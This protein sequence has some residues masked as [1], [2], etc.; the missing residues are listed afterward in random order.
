MPILVTKLY[1]PPSRPNIVL[2]PRLVDVLNGG[3]N[4]KLTLVSA[5]AGFGKS[6]LVGEWVNGSRRLAA[7]LSLDEGDNDPTRFL[8]YLTAALQTIRPTIGEGMVAALQSPQPPPVESVVT[9]LL[10]DIA[11]VP[12]SFILVLDDYHLI[13]SPPIDNAL[14]LLM[15]RLPPQM[16]LVIASRK[17][18]ILPLPRLRVRGQ[19]TEL[20]AADLRFTVEET[21]DFLNR[22]MGLTLST[23]EIAALEKRTEG[24]IA[25]LQLA[26]LALQGSISLQGQGDTAGFIQSFS[27]S[28]RFVLD[29]LVEEVFQQQPEKVQTFLL[30]T[31]I[32]DRLCAPLC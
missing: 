32:L 23:D 17:D 22:A 7:W 14:A 29:Y 6:T 20:R 2:R 31:S 28:H 21:A 19:L 13:D 5:P 3:L 18:P 30:H 4:R 12:D 27:G 26:A 10:N 24:W 25:G 15:E 11:A 8:V 9:T 16:H 1:I